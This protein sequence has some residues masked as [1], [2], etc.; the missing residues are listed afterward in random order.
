MS[1]KLDAA[2]QKE[3][4]YVDQKYKKMNNRR[5]VVN[6]VATGALLGVGYLGTKSIVKNENSA[7]KEALAG[8]TDFV[9]KHANNG[10]KHID[11]KEK[12]T[13]VTT[14]LQKAKDAPAKTKALAVFGAFI[15]MEL[16]NFTK[17]NSYLKG[18]FNQAKA[19]E[20]LVRTNKTITDYYNQPAIEKLD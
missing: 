3:Q 20:K 14:L 7:L 8:T 16:L 18:V 6:T 19:D 17:I 11:K 9:L 12:L 10:I 5:A 2:I 15:A 4:Q 1:V 13:K